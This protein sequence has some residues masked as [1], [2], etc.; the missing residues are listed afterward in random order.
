MGGIAQRMIRLFWPYV[1]EQIE[2]NK[3][4][5]PTFLTMETSQY[6]LA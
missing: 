5:P 4:T 6:Y 1:L 2:F 3:D